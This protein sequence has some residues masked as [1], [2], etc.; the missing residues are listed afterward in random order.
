[1][2]RGCGV[3]SGSGET[4][5]G[6]RCAHHLDFRGAVARRHQLCLPVRGAQPC[7]ILPTCACTHQASQLAPPSPRTRPPNPALSLRRL[8]CRRILRVLARLPPRSRTPVDQ[9]PSIC[10]RHPPLPLERDA[11]LVS[12]RRL[13]VLAAPPPSSDRA[14]SLGPRHTRSAR[15][16]RRAPSCRCISPTCGRQGALRGTRVQTCP[17]RARAGDPVVG[18]ACVLALLLLL[19]AMVRQA[20]CC[21]LFPADVLW[22]A[23]TSEATAQDGVKAVRLPLFP[24]SLARL[25]GP[26]HAV[27]ADSDQ[28]A[29]TGQT[30]EEADRAPAARVRVVRRAHGPT[31]PVLDRVRFLVVLSS[32]ALLGADL[33]RLDVQR[34]YDRLCV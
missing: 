7:A 14:P 2:R 21:A 30:P 23:V 3:V 13:V 20:D 34:E 24:P 5:S 18:R 28:C 31:R 25:S 22:K 6:G 12:T 11:P 26:T 17:E 10:T 19:P 27:P 9:Q 8:W 4:P 16:T 15:G 33:L 29:R 32:P 1:M